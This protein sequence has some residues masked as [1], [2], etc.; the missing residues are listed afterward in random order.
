MTDAGAPKPKRRFRIRL[1][2][3]AAEAIKRREAE[4]AA[5]KAKEQKPLKDV[6]GYNPY[7]RTRH[8]TRFAPGERGRVDPPALGGDK[9]LPKDPF[10]G[11]G[12]RRG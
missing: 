10:G 3:R 8:T 2:D 9:H 7:A 1:L 11:V 4:Q 6:V 5:A 12:R